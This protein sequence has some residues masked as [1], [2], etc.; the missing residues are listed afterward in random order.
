MVGTDE[1]PHQQNKND[2]KMNIEE[3]FH[4]RGK[5]AVVVGGAGYLCSTLSGAFLESGMK[6]VILD[7]A[8]EPPADLSGKAL[9]LNANA[10]SKQ[11]LI[12]ARETILKTFVK[13]DVLL[14]GATVNAPT[15]F[16]EITEEEMDRI[17]AANVKAV[18][19]ACQVFSRRSGVK[20]ILLMKNGKS[21]FCATLPWGVLESQRS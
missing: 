5:V 1:G 4:L 6:V 16:L 15:P 18:F 9:Y 11:G 10:I 19:F 2:N 21:I 20:N 13:V 8:K 14:N 12:E 3:R 17:L 7:M